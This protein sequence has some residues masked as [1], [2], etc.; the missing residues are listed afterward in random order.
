VSAIDTLRDALFGNPPSLTK[1]PSREGVLAAFSELNV[2]VAAVV[3][4]QGDPTE[5]LALIQQAIDQTNA[6]AAT[7][8][9]SLPG[10]ARSGSI[11]DRDAIPL[12][13]RKRG[14]TFKVT[15]DAS[16]LFQEWREYEWRLAGD[17]D[18]PTRE[19]GFLAQAQWCFLWTERE[20]QQLD[21]IPFQ[22]TLPAANV[23]QMPTALANIGEL[24]QPRIYGFRA[25]ALSTTSPLRAMLE[26]DGEADGFTLSWG[27]FTLPIGGGIRAIDTQAF[28]YDALRPLLFTGDSMLDNTWAASAAADLGRDAV[29]VA[30]YSSGAKQVYRL[31]VRKLLCTA[32]GNTIP[33]SGTSVAVTS[34]NGVAPSASAVG[35]NPASFD[36]FAAHGFLSTFAGDTISTHCSEAGTW[37][38]RHGLMSVPNGGT[39]SYKF[40]ADD[41]LGATPI[42]PQSPFVPDNLA[43]LKTHE[44]T[45]RL[46]QN[47]AFAGPGNPVFPN[48]INPRV[49]ED[50]QL[51]AAETVGQ[52]I[53]V[54][55]L[56]PQNNWTTGTPFYTALRYLNGTQANGYTDGQFYQLFGDRYAIVTVGG[57][58]YNNSDYVRWFG[59]DGSSNDQ[60]D[61]DAGIN[62]RSVMETTT[63]NDVHY[64][65]KGEGLEKAFW[66]LWRQQR[67]RP[68]VIT[69][70][71]LFTLMGKRTQPAIYPE[72]PVASTSEPVT[73]GV[74]YGYEVGLRKLAT[75]SLVARMLSDAP[76]PQLM[77]ATD[78][79]LASNWA[80]AAS[81]GT[82]AV[83]AGSV[84]NLDNQLFPIPG[85]FGYQ[86]ELQDPAKQQRVE[87]VSP[88]F[89]PID[90]SDSGFAQGDVV[91][92]AIFTR[93][94]TVDP[95]VD[96][97]KYAQF[98]FNMGVNRAN[99]PMT[100]SVEVG[101]GWACYY[102]QRTLSA[103]DIAD[104][105]SSGSINGFMLRTQAAASDLFS[106]VLA[107]PIIFKGSSLGFLRFLQADLALAV[108]SARTLAIEDQLRGPV[109]AFEGDSRTIQGQ[110]GSGLKYLSNRSYVHWLR[111]LSRQNFD[112]TPALN[113]GRSGWRTDELL[114]VLPADIAA[115]KAASVEVC[116]L[117][118]STNDRNAT[119]PAT[120]VK[121]TSADS[122]ANLT[123]MINMLKTA[124]IRV[125][126][127]NETPR[128]D[129]SGALKTEHVAVRDGINAMHNP[130]GGV[131]VADTWNALAD[132]T[133]PTIAASWA[134]VD[135]I[136]MT[137]RGTFVQ[138]RAVRA[139]LAMFLP[140]AR[141]VVPRDG[142]QMI[143]RN[144]NLL[145]NALM[146]GLGTVVDNFSYTNS[147]GG[148]AAAANSIYTDAVGRKWQKA[149]L[150]GTPSGSDAS[151]VFHRW[152]VNI[153]L[154]KSQFQAG[155]VID[156]TL[157]VMV[158]TPS[159]IRSF[160]MMIVG[161]NIFDGASDI[162]A[163][164]A[165]Y[166][167]GPD[168]YSGVL[169][170]LPVTLTGEP[171]NLQMRVRA[172]VA[173]AVPTSATV[174]FRLSAIRRL[175]R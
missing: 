175:N 70:S 154:Y 22:G 169:R 172:V 146:A 50:L 94:L 86:F 75:G 58:K 164:T 4:E 112:T 7:F 73:T 77:P 104:T 156:A 153:D 29:V 69:S 38:G 81:S 110:I 137:V 76:S 90:L 51:I 117:L 57:Q 60:T 109:V 74:G 32:A 174:Y 97:T 116:C 82:G 95:L 91:T 67:K 155:D 14:L 113:F 17:R 170:T 165:G 151:P 145:P 79:K 142:V 44:V 42:D 26:W 84:V 1:Q 99:I 47:Y 24:Y 63:S 18:G 48:D 12:D 130:F 16:G 101:N 134:T 135:G 102:V 160:D 78:V 80:I 15:Q 34:I 25:I 98:G 125:V 66:L 171:A 173:N 168:S 157:E 118:A 92:L 83:Q 143:A 5:A 2:L 132:S 40:T 128:T 55:G 108:N 103:A 20:R 45:A 124:G 59:R 37:G 147:A 89:T 6:A 121:Y 127:S 161:P 54:L 131:A 53:T 123:A 9:G 100:T 115:M 46:S 120:G 105:V 13:Q 71:T 3:A 30:K 133:D 52:P 31:G 122:L 126:I 139:A 129:L 23:E 167:L 33:A 61:Y 148:S 159:G 88:Y 144:G 85:L 36:L 93:A 111:M 68:P 141:E 35:D 11:A 166:Q 19:G 27:N 8:N 136:H 107:A 64:N 62:P 152:T 140:R 10:I 56:S 39:P 72:E 114:A 106:G 96:P 87:I 163:A 65:A 158:E 41:G 119:N 138:G 162:A 149:V 21:I 43:R 49:L 150:S 28:D